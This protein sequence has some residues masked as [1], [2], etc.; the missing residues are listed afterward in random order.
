[1]LEPEGGKR[2]R[3]MSGPRDDR[4]MGGDAM[5]GPMDQEMPADKGDKGMPEAEPNPMDDLKI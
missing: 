4:D 2:S 5:Q 1:M 3:E